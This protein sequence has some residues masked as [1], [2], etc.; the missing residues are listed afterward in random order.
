MSLI[1]EGRAGNNGKRGPG[2]S[3]VTDWSLL[4]AAAR[5]VRRSLVRRRKDGAPLSWHHIVARMGMASPFVRRLQKD[6][7]VETGALWRSTCPDQPI[8]N[9]QM[10]GTLTGNWTEPPRPASP[11]PRGDSMRSLPALSPFK[12]G[13]YNEPGS[14]QTP[15]WERPPR[16]D[17]P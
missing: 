6:A 9:R 14:V 12:N 7:A 10:D 2:S 17:R 13:S 11:S 15:M 8:R 4:V 1:Q 16:R 5:L 3:L